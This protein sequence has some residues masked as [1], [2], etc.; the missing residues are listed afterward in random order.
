[1]STA[2]RETKAVIDPGPLTGGIAKELV[3]SFIPTHEEGDTLTITVHGSNPET[4]RRG[5]RL[6]V[7]ART[8]HGRPVRTTGQARG[9]P[10]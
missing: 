10:G 9:V 1:M 2:G 6:P 5:G 3:S 7:R 4:G 8:V